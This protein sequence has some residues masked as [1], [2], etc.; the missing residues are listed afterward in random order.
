MRARAR[1]RQRTAY[2]AQHKTTARR[3]EGNLTH[4]APLRFVVLCDVTARCVRIHRGHTEATRERECSFIGMLS[5]SRTRM[6]LPIVG[7]CRRFAVRGLGN[8]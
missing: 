8:K 7:G 3:D 6:R 1:V 5:L 2:R 4:F